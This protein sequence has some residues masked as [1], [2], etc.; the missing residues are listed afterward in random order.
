MRKIT[1]L[2][3]VLIAFSLTV[4]SQTG[5]NQVDSNLP[6]GN[7]VGQISVGIND[8]AAMWVLP[9]N[10]DGSINDAF[11]RSVDGGETWQLGSFGVG[12]GLSQLFAIDANTCWA[13]FN[14]GSSQGLYKTV[15]G[16][17]VWEKKGGV[18]GSSSFAN[19]IHF[20]D[21]NNG[22]AQGDPVDGYYELYTTTDGGEI[23]TR[24]LEASI[25]VPTSGEYGITG[26]YCASGNSIWW[27]TNKG[28][29]FSSTDMGYTWEAALTAF[30]E[31]EVVAPLMFDELNG[32]AY[33]SYLN[34][35]IEPILN[36][37]SDGGITWTEFNTSGAAFGRYFAHVQGTANTIY[38][39][40][41]SE[42]GMG[43]GLSEDGGHTFTEITIG[44]P[45]QAS[46]WFD[47][48]T[49]LSGTFSV[50]STRSVGGMYIYGNPAP[51]INLE[52]T[53][54]VVDVDLTWNAPS[55]PISTSFNDDFEGHEDFSIDFSP[56]VNLD[57][58]GSTTYGMTDVEWPHAG[59][60]QSF[61]IFNQDQTIPAVTDAPA[62]SGA[63]FAACFA[64][65]APPN[66]DFMIAPQISIEAG[67]TVD[68]WAKSYTDAYGLERFR[69][70]VSTTGLDPAD[71]TVIS[72]GDYVEAPADDWT[73]FSYPLDAFV[74]EN[75]YVAIQ[76]VSND[77]FILMIDDFSIGMGKSNFVFNAHSPVIGSGVKEICKATSN[78][79][80]QVVNSTRSGNEIIGYNVYRNDIMINSDIV[81]EQN[82]T[83]TELPIGSFEYFVT[84]V[85]SG[86]ESDPS[87]IVEVVV[88]DL[89]EIVNADDFLVYPNPVSDFLNIKAENIIQ[90]SVT[91]T[92]GQV[93][94]VNVIDAND[95]RINTS[96]L[97]SGVY[98]IKIDTQNGSV[99]RKIVIE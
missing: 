87:N 46:V 77:A 34:L 1:F 39:S 10:G 55:P 95:A 74:G 43:I 9:V 67:A 90:V 14:T 35:A 65:T 73:E 28:R 23:W 64:A 92:I 21:D 45:F 26:D 81:I 48:E 76:C 31:A 38:G 16:G 99:T 50:A 53:V 22:F 25:P 57:V 62:H 78:T 52:A 40:S 37:T 19:V 7:G 79:T 70:S 15:D 11:T 88:T 63:K 83:D 75:V 97:E 71:F 2:M 94:L 29:I 41:S 44:Y 68:F 84:A 5:W 59:E 98:I 18:Y 30:G 3:T 61:I 60:E 20:F 6:A 91:N 96:E 72:E 49:G 12:T 80:A 36:E 54:N 27:G 56:W 33:R 51:P 82:Y 47:V 8:A 42:D 85:Y 89:D 86:G 17:N 32:I 69:V 93:V 4:F 13:V 24:V 58:D 66:N